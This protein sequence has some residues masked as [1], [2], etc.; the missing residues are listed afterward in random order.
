MPVVDTA[1]GAICLMVNH[2]LS[3]NILKLPPYIIYIK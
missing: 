2:D 3:G 1:K